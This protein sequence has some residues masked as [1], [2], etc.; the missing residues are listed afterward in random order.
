[1]NAVVII[2]F[3]IALRRVG[4]CSIDITNLYSSIE[5]YVECHFDIVLDLLP[6]Y[7]RAHNCTRRHKPRHVVDP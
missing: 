6:T 7:D 2:T 5:K 1:M 4:L 3:F